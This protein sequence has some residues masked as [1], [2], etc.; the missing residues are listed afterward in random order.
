MLLY[1]LVICGYCGSDEFQDVEWQGAMR[2]MGE[3]FQKEVVEGGL[4]R[5]CLELGNNDLK[6]LVQVV[7]DLLLQFFPVPGKDS[8]L[9]LGI[10]IIEN[11]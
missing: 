7:K 10:L 11:F 6:A 2:E 4:I 1:N 8:D 9:Q 5:D 3:T